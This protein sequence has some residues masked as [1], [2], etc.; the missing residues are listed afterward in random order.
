MGGVE[1]ALCYVQPDGT[2]RDECSLQFPS[3]RNETINYYVYLD[4][5][6]AESIHVSRATKDRPFTATLGKQHSSLKLPLLKAASVFD[7]NSIQLEA[8]LPSVFV[9]SY[10]WTTHNVKLSFVQ[11][12]PSNLDK[13]VRYILRPNDSFKIGERQFVLQVRQTVLD[14]EVQV[15]SSRPNEVDNGA[16]D[17]EDVQDSKPFSRTRPSTPGPGSGPAVMETPIT[18]RHHPPLDA[19][20]HPKAKPSSSNSASSTPTKPQAL[21][22][23]LGNPDEDNSEKHVSGAKMPLA[24]VR[25]S[26]NANG[27]MTGPVSGPQSPITDGDLSLQIPKPSGQRSP[28]LKPSQKEK[29]RRTRKRSDS[30]DHIGEHLAAGAPTIVDLESAPSIDETSSEDPPRKRQ[31][32]VLGSHATIK[33]ADESQNSVRSTINVD[34]PNM[35]QSLAL[36]PESQTIP[37]QESGQ[38]LESPESNPSEEDNGSTPRNYAKSAEPPSSNRSTRSAAQAQQEQDLSQNQTLRVYYAS[39]TKIEESTVYTRFLRQH[40]IKQVKNVADCDILCTGK[41][42]LKRTSNL[43]LAVLMGK[44]VVTDQWVVQSAQKHKVL[45]TTDFVPENPAREREW[46]TSL[47]DAIDRGRR[48]LKP[49]EGWTINFTPSI[50]KELGKSWSE[51]KEVCLAAGAAAVQAMIPRKSPAESGATVLI[52][53]SHE[54]DL[55][56][57]EERGWRVFTKDIITYSVLRGE[58]DTS[59]DEFLMRSTKKGSAGG[60]KKK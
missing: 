5:K 49:L 15:T 31:K 7:Q 24:E 60:K 37:V 2:L 17:Q 11:L 32:R 9:K 16:I 1:A 3:S 36:N 27:S 53:A 8:W 13:R 57:L 42:E 18:S 22:D 47:S 38:V 20:E 10:E 14:Q 4:V 26:G 30:R 45:D 52:A 51:L 23:D 6:D 35:E 59:S 44:D 56:T 40:N 39:S 12:S 41:G 29:A 28:I 33:G 25:Y 55:S 43:I 50:K 46:G 48:G 34:V 54:P 58:V 19:F 21:N